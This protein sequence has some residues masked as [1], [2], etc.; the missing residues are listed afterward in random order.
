MHPLNIHTCGRCGQQ[1]AHT[2]YCP[3]L[4]VPPPLP[5]TGAQIVRQLTEEDVRRIVREELAR[6]AAMTGEGG[7]P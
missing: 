4:N 6:A 3:S 7:K 1:W 2:H 5:M